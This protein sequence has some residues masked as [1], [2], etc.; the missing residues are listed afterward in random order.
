MKR[1]VALLLVLVMFESAVSS[2]LAVN[3]DQNFVFGS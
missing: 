3:T 2:A 1:F